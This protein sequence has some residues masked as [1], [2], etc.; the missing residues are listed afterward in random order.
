MLYLAA[1]G[2][3]AASAER[4]RWDLESNT[5][6]FVNMP[7][8][9]SGRSRRLRVVGRGLRRA[10]RRRDAG[11][12]GRRRGCRTRSRSWR[13]S[14]TCGSSASTAAPC[15]ATSTSA[16]SAPTARTRRR[17]RSR[18]SGCRRWRAASASSSIRGDGENLID[19]MYVDDAVDGFLALVKARG[20]KLTVDFASGAPVSV[21]DVVRDDGVRRSASTCRSATKARSPNTSSSDRRI[22]TMRDRFGVAPTI[23][24]DDGLRAAVGAFSAR[25][26]MAPVDPREA[27]ARRELHEYVAEVEGHDSQVTGV[28]GYFYEMY[29]REVL[30]RVDRRAEPRHPRSRLRRRHDVRR[31]RR[32]AR[33]RWTCR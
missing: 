14:S 15:R 23:S 29:R 30:A 6:A 20:A 1:N 26:G 5:V 10:A 2:D 28:V 18:R 17:A 11:D 19:F 7:R 3:P 31:H 25:S 12:A 21:N 13:P 33:C 24:F 16:S 9:V 8:A 4:P 27:D 22:T 32:S